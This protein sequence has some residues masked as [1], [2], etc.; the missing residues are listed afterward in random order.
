MK[1]IAIDM[2]EVIAD[3]VSKHLHLY[4]TNFNESLTV[5]DLHGTRLWTIRP[6]LSKE[7]LDYVDDPLFFRDLKVIK[8]S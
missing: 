8:G 3:F 7:I 5:D 2:D 4:N 1:R 6:H